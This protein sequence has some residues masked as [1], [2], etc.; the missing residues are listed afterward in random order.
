MLPMKLVVYL[1][2][3]CPHCGGE[4][5]QIDD[6]RTGLAVRAL[7]RSKGLSMAEL[8]SRI[9]ISES[10]MSQL[11]LGNRPWNNELEAK[12]AAALNGNGQA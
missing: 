3:D 9:G 7:R 11:E 10:Y 4:G 2:Q 6:R 8:G 12:A 1:K 5:R